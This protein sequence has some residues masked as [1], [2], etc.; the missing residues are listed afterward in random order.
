MFQRERDEILHVIDDL[1]QRK[2]VLWEE[3]QSLLSHV[4]TS[5]QEIESITGII[6][7]SKREKEELDEMLKMIPKVSEF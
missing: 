3:S 2:Q 1:N 5:R 4:Q 7:E 6:G